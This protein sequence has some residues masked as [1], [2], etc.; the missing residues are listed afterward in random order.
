MKKDL[1]KEINSLPP[2][3][4]SVI[5]LEKYKVAQNTNINNLISKFRR[6]ILDCILKIE[7]NIDYPEYESEEQITTEFLLPTIKNN[8]KKKRLLNNNRFLRK[9]IY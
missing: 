1:I 6:S 8:I 2:L 7:V 3:P 9:F 5:K 4:S